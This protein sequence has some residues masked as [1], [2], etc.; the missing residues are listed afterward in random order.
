[1]HTGAL[2]KAR[3][4]KLFPLVVTILIALAATA[5]DAATSKQKKSP[6]AAAPAA[7][8]P[9]AAPAKAE[10]PPPAAA[11][12][13]AKEWG[14]YLDIAY[15]LTYW[16]KGEI[17]DW[18][19][20][21]E[22]QIGQPLSDYIKTWS[23]KLMTPPGAPLAAKEGDQDQVYRERDYLRLAI[24]ETLDYLA[25]DNRESLS[26]AAQVLDKLKNRASM[27]EISY[28]M[29]YVKALEAIEN[30]DSSD[31]VA[32][33]Y[34]LW[35]N[36]VLFMEQN[37]LLSP[38]AD[39]AA[40]SAVQFQYRNL[41]TLVANRAI[42]DR[43]MDNLDALGPLFL[44][45]KDRN[46][47]ETKEEGQYLTLLTKR[48]AEDLTSPD[49]DRYRLNFT[50]A[51]IE[52]RRL[53]QKAA[54]KLDSAGMTDEAMKLF[55]QSRLF[56]DRAFNA[57]ASRRSS[58]AVSAIV[59][60]LDLT[61]FAIQRLP[62]NEKAP[63]YKFFSMLPSHDGSSTILAAMAM[64]NDIA[65]YTA[66]G[67]EKAGYATR[68][69]YI[70]SA[71]RL[72]RSIME[73]SLWTG[74]FYMTKLNAATKPK[75]IFEP[76]APL[77][78]ALNTY[79]EFLA[80]QHAR[81]YNDAIPDFAY[82]GA[83][84]AAD[85]LALSYQKTYVYGTDSSEYNL[86]FLRRLQ[87][88]ELF[89]FDGQEV[90]RTAAALRHDGRYNL[91]LDYFL[92]VAERLKQSEAV[93]KWLDYQKGDLGTLVR[94]YVNSAEKVYAPTASGNNPALQSANAA[95]FLQLREELQRNPDHPLHRLIK[96]FY[97]EEMGKRTPFTLL[98]KDPSRINYGM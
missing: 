94:E 18:R 8:A 40:E 12:A 24:A 55:Q 4:G 53:Q 33:V 20:K 75:Q 36:S 23:A 85:K 49:S 56:Y 81:G 10:T 28:W 29:G 65:P 95:K 32:R 22:K 17:I 48:I 61:S 6:P 42:I 88:T 60:Y 16:D 3:S 96:A 63:E 25:N 19:G 76:A 9:A 71:H 86:W 51:L 14:P 41:I 58:G 72:W 77:Q 62:D 79:L 39:A 52:A 43:K 31:F 15:E 82:F 26:N 54:A 37:A 84:E 35:N 89:P 2:R 98:L 83:A 47:G 7:A 13:A 92:P 97:V 44:M 59:G 45:L 93:G 78:V 68:E 57:A 74:D 21:L 1:M 70:K 69:A 91:F 30:G 50:V 73:L 66:G 64:Y 46:L 5:A 38:G 80:S 34:G 67:W 87:A 90:A 27:P 11:P